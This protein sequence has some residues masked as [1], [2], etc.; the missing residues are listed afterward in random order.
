VWEVILAS[1]SAPAILPPLQRN[2]VYYADGGTGSYGNPAYVAAREAVDWAKY[3][4]RD[5]TLLSFGTGW[6]SAT[7]FEKAVGK[8]SNWHLID[9]A[10]NI[11]NVMIADAARS[12]SIDIV[13]DYMRDEENAMD[14]RRFQIALDRDFEAFGPTDEGN[15][16]MIE[17]GKKMGQ[18]IINNQHALGDDPN[19]DP[20]G[21]RDLL[22]RYRK[23]KAEGG[24]A[25]S[26]TPQ[27]GK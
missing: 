8:P 17:V 19:Y 15:K 14:F 9:W 6:L 21:I 13:D 5:V 27:K 26:K 24:A 22:L 4:P 16:G 12:Q 18:Q 10:H 20:E 2:G 7:N 3:D 23:S 1:S 11:P 25:E